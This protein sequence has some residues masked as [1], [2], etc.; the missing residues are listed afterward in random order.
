MV[1]GVIDHIVIFKH[2][3]DA[4]MALYREVYQDMQKKAEQLRITSSSQILLLPP[5]LCILH[6]S[7]NLTTSSQNAS[8]ILLLM[9]SVLMFV[10]G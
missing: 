4:V 8:D 1:D 9:I 6:H 5:L 3:S 2:E 10:S 7:L